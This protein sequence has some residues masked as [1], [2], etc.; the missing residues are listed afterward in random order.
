[1]SWEKMGCLPPHREKQN[2]NMPGV[3]ELRSFS[4][5]KE[6]QRLTKDDIFRRGVDGDQQWHRGGNEHN[7]WEPLREGV[8]H[9]LGGLQEVLTRLPT[10]GFGRGSSTVAVRCVLEGGDH[11]VLMRSLP[12]GRR[13]WGQKRVE[14]G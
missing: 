1:M 14:R 9:Q 7:S 13:K 12:S 3:R 4:N 5:K 6:G 2:Q 10:E 11:G 8:S